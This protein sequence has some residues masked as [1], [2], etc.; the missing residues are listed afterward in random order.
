MDGFFNTLVYQLGEIVMRHHQRSLMLLLFFISLGASAEP[1]KPLDRQEIVA[2]WDLGAANKET[3]LPLQQRMEK[4]AWHIEQGQYA[5]QANKH[6]GRA[7]ALLSPLFDSAQSA[8]LST[9]NNISQSYTLYLWSRVLQHQHQFVQAINYLN[10]SIE[11]NPDNSAA[12][13]LKANVLLTQGKFA[14]SKQT[15]T[16]LIGKADLLLTTACVL[17]VMANQDQLSAG[18][19]QLSQL[20]NQQSLLN[21]KQKQE[22]LLQ[23]AA[24]MALRLNKYQEAEQW[25]AMALSNV[26]EGSGKLNL[27][28]KPLSFIVL[29]AD[30]QLSLRQT[31]PVL[32]QLSYVVEQAGFKDDALLTRLSLA[33][34]TTAKTKWQSLLTERIELRLARQDKFHS[35]DLARFYLDIVPNPEQALYWARINWQQAKL[36][37][38]KQLLDRALMMQNIDS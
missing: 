33:E 30:V 3:S 21:S 28:Q 6:Y 23:L 35:A 32:V 24:D 7:R 15:C 2:R 38:D 11:L 9:E 10:Q 36:N 19:V 16:Q 1:Y 26:S 20:L 14:Q 27:A 12:I 5:G 31:N 8:Q 29:W 22:W 13:L 37:D 18:Y 25:L 17:E 34:K 4:V